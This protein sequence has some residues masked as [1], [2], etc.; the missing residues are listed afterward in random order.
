MRDIFSIKRRVDAMLRFE[1][2]LAR[3]E[4]VCGV[5]PA[6]AA[7]AIAAAADPPRI[8]FDEIVV[9]TQNVGYPVI[10]LTEQ[11]A[12]LAGDAGRYVHWGA[13]TQDVLDTAMVLQMHDGFALLRS[14]LAAIVAALADRA[15]NHRDDL[16]A[17]R[18]HLQHALP[19]TFGYACSQWLSPLVAH[20]GTL[21]RYH[22]RIDTLQFGGAVGTLASLGESARDV[23]LALARE[24]GLH[25]PDSPWHVDRSA[26]AE[27]A[28][29]IGTTCGSLA[30]FATDVVLLMQSDVAEVFEPDAP[31]R[32]GSSSMPQ[33]RNPIACEYV[34]A[35]TRGVHA[36]VP[37]VLAAMAGDHQRSTGPWQSEEIA[38]PQIFV[39]ASAAFAQAR[40]VA[41][42]MTADTARMRVNLDAGEGL[43]LAE[44]VSTALARHLGRGCAHTIVK[45][46]CSVAVA[47]RRPLLDVLAED[48]EVTAVVD[49]ST[50][51]RLLDPANYLGDAQAIVDRV[52][53]RARNALV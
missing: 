25:A 32:G 31:G 52:V 26:F 10:A 45:R 22:E 18:T 44:G 47:Q 3:A 37:M 9:S 1:V 41:E 16:M 4:A 5:I 39:L 17:G 34:L 38:L 33:K 7:E 29:A 48:P 8:D 14:D 20:V 27:A 35:A 51:V 2:A 12:A 19:I 11:L 28:C 15:E 40:V 49:R 23:T 36:L 53:R 13:T 46:A 50:L 30:K 21:R 24:L 42:G 6:D 43:I